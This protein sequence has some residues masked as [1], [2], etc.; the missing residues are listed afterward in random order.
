MAASRGDKPEGPALDDGAE[1][2]AATG[3]EAAERPHADVGGPVGAGLEDRSQATSAALGAT[4]DS[5][6]R[7]GKAEVVVEALEGAVAEAEV[8]D[9]WEPAAEEARVMLWG[10]GCAD[11]CGGE[12]GSE[13]FFSG[14]R[15]D[16]DAKVME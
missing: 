13:G 15:H 16:D 6:L 11:V 5:A 10:T 2:G 8:V 1:S 4:R 9:E 14:E 3:A 7:E 12:R